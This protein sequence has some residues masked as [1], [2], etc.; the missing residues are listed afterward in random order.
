MR[1]VTARSERLRDGGAVDLTVVVPFTRPWAVDRFFDGLE[2]SG[3]PVA[4]SALLVYVD[5]DSGELYRAV[6]ARAEGGAW[7]SV[8]LHTTG[9]PPPEEFANATRRRFRHCAMRLA[10]RGLL[11]R[12][13]LLLAT[14]D[15]TLWPEGGYTRLAATYAQG[16]ADIVS[17][18][19]V[20]RWGVVQPPG[21]WQ[22]D[23]GP[24]RKMIAVLPDGDASYVDAVGLYA[25]LCDAA[26]YRALDFRTWDNA[27][28]QDVSVTYAATRAGVRVLVDWHVGLGHMLERKVIPPHAAAP[29]ERTAEMRTIMTPSGPFWV[30][31]PKEATVS[32]GDTYRTKQ[33]I[34][35]PV[36]GEIICGK[37]TDLKMSEA[38][39]YARRGLL[40][41][42]AVNMF[43]HSGKVMPGVETKPVAADEAP[44]LALLADV[45]GAPAP[46]E[47]PEGPPYACKV[48]GREYKTMKGR[49]DH[50]ANKH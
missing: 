1:C 31:E 34:T 44:S 35:D 24:P 2:A 13:G 42:P 9:W 39:E 36:T 29:Y 20:N 47:T 14:E 12:E 18:W 10:L 41:D 8:W 25:L 6:R 37:G 3:V 23:E 5:S 26:V 46:V 28:G 45:E 48:C 7:R 40:S 4:S 16:A 50:E 30:H 49:D 33:R 11:P 32:R 27:I 15:D 22:I 19:Q 38:I 43:A 21:V 17:G